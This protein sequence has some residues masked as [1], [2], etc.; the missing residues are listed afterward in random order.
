MAT[1]INTALIPS[2]NLMYENQ[3]DAIIIQDN[4]T[5]HKSKE[6]KKIVEEEKLNF[7]EGYPASSPDM[8]PIENIWDLWDRKVH[9]HRINNLEELHYFAQLEWD[10]LKQNKELL[11]KLVMTY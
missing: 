5:K 1:I 7:M 6:V 11:N 8:N 2:L 4:D 9:S 10:N 3:T